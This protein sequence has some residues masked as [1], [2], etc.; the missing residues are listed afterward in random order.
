MG[1]MSLLSFMKFFVRF[2]LGIIFVENS[3]ILSV[4]YTCFGASHVIAPIPFNS[5]KDLQLDMVSK[6]VKYLPATNHSGEE[7]PNRIAPST[8][9]L[10]FACSKHN[11]KVVYDCFSLLIHR[12]GGGKS[13]NQFLLAKQKSSLKIMLTLR[14]C[15]RVCE[16]C[17]SLVGANWGVFATMLGIQLAIDQG[18]DLVLSDD[19]CS[20]NWLMALN[21]SKS[22]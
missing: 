11:R 8:T 21:K 16:I 4:E 19:T 18:K 20:T 15:V 12:F 17:P 14:R 9:G 1:S 5:N 10:T 3:S 7:V 6:C 2:S 22:S 13:T